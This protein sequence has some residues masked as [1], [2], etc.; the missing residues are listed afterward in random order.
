M[1]RWICIC[2][3]LGG[4]HN[5]GHCCCRVWL[6]LM[7]DGSDPPIVLPRGRGD[8]CVG[9]VGSWGGGKKLVGQG[10][11]PRLGTAL[12]RI[13]EGWLIRDKSHFRRKGPCDH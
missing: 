5:N 8:P 10:T 7:K 4:R 1:M 11:Q 12:V 3:D 2:L 6:F 13:A 9:S